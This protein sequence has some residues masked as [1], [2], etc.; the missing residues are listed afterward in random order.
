M[1]ITVLCFAQLK[2]FFAAQSKLELDLGLDVHA[3]CEK[4]LEGLPADRRAK[5]RALIAACRFSIGDEFVENDFCLEEGLV[6]CLLP[7][8][9]GG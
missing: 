4:L 1:Q 9:S 7:P 2:E 5:A 6:L 3:A 8:P